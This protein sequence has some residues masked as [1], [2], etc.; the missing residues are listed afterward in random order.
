[1]MMDLLISIHETLL[2]YIFRIYVFKHREV[3]NFYLH[4]ELFYLPLCSDP[5]YPENPFSLNHMS[6]IKIAML[7]FYL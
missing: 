4:G 2:L 3:Q 5:H 1:M 7:A 6:A